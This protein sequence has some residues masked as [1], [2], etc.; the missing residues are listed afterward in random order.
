M[1]RHI[2]SKSLKCRLNCKTECDT[3]FSNLDIYGRRQSIGSVANRKGSFGQK[4][5]GQTLSLE[6]VFEDEK[7]KENV[8]VTCRE[9]SVGST[10]G[11][12]SISGYS[13]LQDSN[14]YFIGIEDARGKNDCDTC[15]CK[16]CMCDSCQ[17]MEI[18]TP[19]AQVLSKLNSVRSNLQ[20]VL[21]VM[22]EQGINFTNSLI[23]ADVSGSQTK[24]GVGQPYLKQSKVSL[25]DLD[26]CL[27]QLETLCSHQSVADMTR[28]KFI[29]LL[30][31]EIKKLPKYKIILDM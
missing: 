22:S 13:R 3:E 25:A 31:K 16:R 14:S 2:R 21:N 4:P 17:C 12:R 10:I 8:N 11:S 27:D 23:K 6:L 19:F 28:E 18:V 24:I 5:L 9:R 20:N 7:Q 1:G 26:W 30:A 15:A 29:N